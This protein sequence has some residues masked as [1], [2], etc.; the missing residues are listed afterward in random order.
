MGI[1][2]EDK[3][4]CVVEIGGYCQVHKQQ[5]GICY[6]IR[7][8]SLI[9]GPS[10]IPMLLT[11]PKCGFPHIDEGEWAERHHKT[12][13]CLKPGCG[14]TWRPANVPTVGVEKLP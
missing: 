3:R 11:C 2:P 1:T 14:H 8:D 13:L 12:H 4:P 5:R 10:P 7:P 9:S 6:T